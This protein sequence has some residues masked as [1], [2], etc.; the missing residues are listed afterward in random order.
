MIR[1]NCSLVKKSKA[2]VALDSMDLAL[3]SEE[4][5]R[6]K[7]KT[8]SLIIDPTEKIQKT[9]AEG[10]VMLTSSPEFSDKKVEGS[11]ITIQG[12]GE[13]EVGGIKIS[14]TRVDKK[15]V[16]TVYVDN[17]KILIGSGDSIEKIKDKI[18]NCQ[19]AVVRADEAFNNSMLTSLEPRALLLYGP[20]KDEV[21]KSMG[22]EGVKAAKYSTN[23]DRLPEE[24]D[25]VILG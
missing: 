18:G 10:I 5:L 13:Y 9:E 3:L 7:G 2:V 17:L 15:L 4:S 11:R 21:Q 16:A 25:F 14:A 22:K 8:A 23:A 24:M 6:V 20:N 12:P 1:L 19:L